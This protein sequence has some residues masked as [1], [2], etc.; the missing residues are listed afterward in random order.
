M[1]TGIAEMVNA[2]AIE[3]CVIAVKTPGIKPAMRDIIVMRMVAIVLTVN[4]LLDV[5]SYDGL[6][7]VIPTPMK[8]PLAIIT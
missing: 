6:N 5:S 3:S 1:G 2:D 4:A 8:M 7:A